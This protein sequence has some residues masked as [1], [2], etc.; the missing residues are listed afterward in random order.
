[1]EER[2]GEEGGVGGHDEGGRARREGWVAMM[3]E[4]GEG[5]V[6]GHDEG[7]REGWVAMMR[8]GEEGGEGGVGSHDEGWREVK[9][10]GG[11]EV[12]TSNEIRL[13]ILTQGRQP[14][15]LLSASTTRPSCHY[16]W[17]WDPL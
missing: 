5:G 10:W 11:I 1:M 7:G 13:Q 14:C 12:C 17:T 9:W 8:E 16:C 2:E 6:G 15:M 4:G 3:R